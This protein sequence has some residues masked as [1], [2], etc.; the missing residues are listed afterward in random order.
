MPVSVILRSVPPRRPSGPGAN[1]RRHIRKYL[2][3][4]KHTPRAVHTAALGRR[5]LH[6][7]LFAS[8]HVRADVS[9]R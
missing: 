9:H 3:I 1:S 7:F 5:L 6:L 4:E 2:S 8:T